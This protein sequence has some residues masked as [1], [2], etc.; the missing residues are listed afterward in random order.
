MTILFWIY[1]FVSQF[2]LC[3]EYEGGCELGG[4]C[5]GMHLGA[6]LHGH[7][8]ILHEPTPLTTK[9]NYHCKYHKKYIALNVKIPMK[10]QI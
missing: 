4:E 3:S 9:R 6:Y 10:E 8:E 5:S 2:I 1:L 7:S